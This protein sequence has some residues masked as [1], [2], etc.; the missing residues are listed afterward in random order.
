MHHVTGIT[1]GRINLLLT[2]GDAVYATR[3]GNSLFT[4]A[5]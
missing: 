4:A 3:W 2:D 5:R 1:T